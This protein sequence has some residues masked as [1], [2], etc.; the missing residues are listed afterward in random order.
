MIFCAAR[1]VEPR[2]AG[3]GFRDEEEMCGLRWHCADEVID[4]TLAGADAAEGEDLSAV[5]LGHG[6]HSHR[7]FV[8]VHADEA[9][10]RLRQG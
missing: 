4:V 10:A 9:C 2:A 7:I 5:I 6:G 3:A 1:A 8:D